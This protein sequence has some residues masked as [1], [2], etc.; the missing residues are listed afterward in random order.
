MG[1]V[2]QLSAK[3][4]ALLVAMILWASPAVAACTASDFDV[5]ITNIKW[6]DKCRNR[7]CPM[8]YGAAIV[9]NHCSSAAGVQ[10]RIV[11]LDKKG[12]PVQVSNFWPFS[13][14]NVAPG[15]HPISLDLHLDY[16]D[17]IAAFR[18][19]VVEA[20]TWDR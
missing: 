19:Q 12:D 2:L 3:A 5:R 4:V 6:V 11:G 8:L 17:A 13:V 9:T 10:L 7:S 16:D 1:R 15:E 20:R 14:S 18:L